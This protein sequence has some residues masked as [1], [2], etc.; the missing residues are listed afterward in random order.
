[1]LS[2]FIH[3]S[4]FQLHLKYIHGVSAFSPQCVFKVCGAL[5]SDC[6]KSCWPSALLELYPRNVIDTK[7]IQPNS[8]VLVIYEEPFRPGGSSIL[9]ID[10]QGMPM[11]H[12]SSALI[13]R[14]MFKCMSLHRPNC[15]PLLHLGKT[16]TCCH[17]WTVGTCCWIRWGGR[18][19]TMQHW[20]TSTSTMSSWGSCKLA[21]TLHGCSRRWGCKSK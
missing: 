11:T 16:K 20:A 4:T 10:C 12:L 5:F 15:C 2:P 7:Y 1:M 6:R 3:N 21:R 14:K 13:H 18:V 17:L 9:D 19:R 8:A